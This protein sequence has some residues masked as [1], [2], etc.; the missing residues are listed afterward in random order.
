MC[1]LRKRIASLVF[2][3][4][5]ISSC[6]L[7]ATASPTTTVITPPPITTIIQPPPVT[8]TPPPIT[9]VIQ[10]P[11]VTVTQTPPPPATEAA[12]RYGWGASL[13][14]SD[15]FNYIGAPDGTKWRV[16]GECWPGHNGNGRRCGSRSTVDGN[17]LIQTGLSNGDS[18][19]LG[20]KTSKRY[21]R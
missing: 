8:V 9:T 19:W 7:S 4:A 12:V 17:K 20:S 5:V 13:P 14:G 15:E 21:G 16:A 1:G 2:V 18:A 10:P 3:A 11:P 6:S